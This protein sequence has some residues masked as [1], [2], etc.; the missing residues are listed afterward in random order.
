M[1]FVAGQLGMETV[2]LKRR[3]V[4]GG[5]MAQTRQVF[6]NIETVLAEAGVNLDHV[7]TMSVYLKDI[8]DLEKFCEVRNAVFKRDFPAS[9]SVQVSEFAVKGALVEV[10]VTAV[11]Q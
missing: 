8:K 10:N 2:G 6:K 1:I 5:I 9:T 11:V 3:L 4:R 7:A